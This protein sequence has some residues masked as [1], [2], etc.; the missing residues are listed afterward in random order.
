[1]TPRSYA[2]PALSALSIV[3]TTT[4][5]SKVDP[6]IGDWVGNKMTQTYTYADGTNQVDTIDL[7]QSYDD[8]AG[9]TYVRTI[10]MTLTDTYSGTFVS[11]TN[12]TYADGSTYVDTLNAALTGTVVERG[13]WAIAMTSAQTSLDLTCTADK[14]LDTVHCDGAPTVDLGDAVT[15]GF[16]FDRAPVVVE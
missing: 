2:L 15:L 14:K 5:C 3:T 11:A 16:D 12:Y 8:G 6:L 9:Y 7:P 13:I 10:A 4:G 1:V